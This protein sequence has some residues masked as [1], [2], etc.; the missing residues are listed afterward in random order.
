M[1]YREERVDGRPQLMG[2]MRDVLER[3]RATITER[4]IVA[5]VLAVAAGFALGRLA[6]R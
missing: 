3:A 4:P 5:L 2:D 6:R 1:D